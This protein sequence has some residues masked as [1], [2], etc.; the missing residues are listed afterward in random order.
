ME[1]KKLTTIRSLLDA[2]ARAMNLI[3]SEV[4]NHHQQTAYFAYFIGREMGFD[5]EDLHLAIYA[6]L[7]HDVG[8]IVMNRVASVAEIEADAEQIANI[9][10]GMLED[11][12]AFGEISKVIRYCQLD[13]RSV[14][15]Y[16][17]DFPE[18]E[19]FLRIASAV[20][21]ADAASALLRY[22]NV[23]NQVDDICRWIEAGKGTHFNPEAVEAFIRLKPLEVVWLDALNNPSFLL[24]FT[25]E[26]HEITVEQTV[27]LTRLMSRI[28]DYRSAFT[29]MHSAGVSA[30]ATILARLAGMGEE[31][32]LKMEIAG[33][34]HDVGKLVVPERILIKPGKLTTEEFNIMK[35]H[36]YYT[37]FVLMDVDGFE[38]IANW[39]G[40]HHEKL[41]GRGY[42]FHWDAEQLDLGCRIMAVAD[43]FS[44]MAE[45]RPYRK[46]MRR[47]QIE[48]ILR[49]DVAG[50]RVDGALVDLL[51][52]NYN[53]VNEVRD[54]ISHREGHRYY[55]SMDRE[56]KAGE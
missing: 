42:P 49:E 48:S 33:N 55:E 6:A 22:G 31:D 3:N 29:A 15:A 9:G 52:E 38:K 8:S 20:H 53:E 23:L 39:A 34:L 36:A 11:L 12:P 2:L 46:G 4:E 16:E 44:A 25:G 30:S 10:A 18:K 32:C 21:T 35:E 5:T 17:R 50:K 47:E 37:R 54:E 43:M 27:E 7:L 24:F 26:M 19:R 28:I 51:F 14:R 13:Y 41:N 56:K 45:D 1:K 40:C